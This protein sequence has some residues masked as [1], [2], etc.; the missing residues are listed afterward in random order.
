MSQI[1]TTIEAAEKFGT[2]AS[3]VSRAAKKAG[4]GLRRADGRLVGINKSD[5]R[6]IEKFLRYRAG[7]PKWVK[8]K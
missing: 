7:N 4:V 2:S 5:L 6:A 3:S 8:K 1:L